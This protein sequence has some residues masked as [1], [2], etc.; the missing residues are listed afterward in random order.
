METITREELQQLMASGTPFKLVEAL[1]GGSFAQGHLPGAINIPPGEVR[2]L[3]PSL[4]PD[5]EQEIV[6]YCGS[7]T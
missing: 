3:A 6:V 5:K 4:L 2:A 1:Q 7:F